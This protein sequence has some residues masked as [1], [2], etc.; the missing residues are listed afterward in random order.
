MISLM[1]EQMTALE[2]LPCV[3]HAVQTGTEGQLVCVWW[4]GLGAPCSTP[5]QMASQMVD[6]YT[7][8]PGQVRSVETALSP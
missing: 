8:G 7:T 6:I 1:G 4:L 5:M 2:D 3:S